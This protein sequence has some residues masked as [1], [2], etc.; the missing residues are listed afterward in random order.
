MGSSISTTDNPVK[1]QGLIDGTIINN[2]VV[3]FS[4][5]RCKYCDKAKTSLSRMGVN[6]KS[7]E[8]DLLGTNSFKVSNELTQK[9]G[10]RTVFNFRIKFLHVQKI[11]KLLRV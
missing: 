3:M 1:T 5:T 2:C 4:T 9:T 8:L 6:F 11:A 10:L 7:V